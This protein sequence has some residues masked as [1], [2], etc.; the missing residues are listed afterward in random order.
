MAKRTDPEEARID[1]FLAPLARVRPAARP[2]RRWALRRLAITGCGFVL[3]LG[4]AAVAADRVFDDDEIL[5]TG[6]IYQGKNA[7]YALAEPLFNG[8]PV[9]G[10]RADEAA[11]EVLPRVYR[12]PLVWRLESWDEEGLRSVEPVESPPPGTV[13]S[14]LGIAPASAVTGDV[15]GK[16]VVFVRDPDDPNGPPIPPVECVDEP[17]GQP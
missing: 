3:L 5:R 2:R 17:G 4:G 14:D 9:V 6:E 7:D 10:M 13:V 15:P 11:E 12:G 8:C 16:D 1:A